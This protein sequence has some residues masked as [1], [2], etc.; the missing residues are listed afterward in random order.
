M[1]YYAVIREAGP[2]WTEGGIAA[3]PDVADNAAFING[4][5]DEGLVLFA[6]PLAGTENGRLRALLIVNA[7]HDDEIRRRLADDP[8]AQA[9]RLVITSIKSWKIRSDGADMSAWCAARSARR[10]LRSM[11]V[12]ER[13]RRP[14]R[15]GGRPEP[16]RRCECGRRA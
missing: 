9:D 2:D 4:L 16:G 11:A 3:Q 12:R 15:A 7:Y 10:A 8:W 6:E 5:A 13:G 14:R 1:S